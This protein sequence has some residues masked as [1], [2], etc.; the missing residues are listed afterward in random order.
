M[1]SARSNLSI[2]STHLMARL[3]VYSRCIVPFRCRYEQVIQF[4]SGI[5]IC[6][7]VDTENL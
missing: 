7:R 3:H 2:G 4:C 1:G 6:V 5:E